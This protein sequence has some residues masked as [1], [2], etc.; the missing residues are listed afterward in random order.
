MA[1]PDLTPLLPTSNFSTTVTAVL[2]VSA[3]II[4]LYLIVKAYFFIASLV[5]GKVY[6]AGRLWDRQVYHRAMQDVNRSIRRGYLVDKESRDAWKRY[7]GIGVNSRR[8]RI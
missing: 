3:S 7:T 5:T 2:S 6:F 4:A 8:P 1:A